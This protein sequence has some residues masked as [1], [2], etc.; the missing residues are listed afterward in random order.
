M[1]D[2]CPC[3]EEVVGT[4]RRGVPACR[5]HASLIFQGKTK[6][7]NKV[8]WETRLEADREASSEKDWR[9]ITVQWDW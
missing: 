4:D 7:S 2:I 9:P 8:D 5:E 6:I 1:N 3:G